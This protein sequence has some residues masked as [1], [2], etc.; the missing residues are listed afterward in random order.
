VRQAARRA[1]NA[2]GEND[3]ARPIVDDLRWRVEILVSSRSPSKR[4]L[5]RSA[6]APGRFSSR[7][8]AEM[9][10]PARSPSLRLLRR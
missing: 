7:V 4:L 8:A 5:R 3:L 10:V 2:E 9:F 6:V 1:S